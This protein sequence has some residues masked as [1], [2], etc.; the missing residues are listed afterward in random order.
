MTALA[1][2]AALIVA[3]EF[4]KAGWHGRW[5]GSHWLYMGHLVAIAAVRFAAAAPG[6]GFIAHMALLSVVATVASYYILLKSYILLQG[7]TGWWWEPLSKRRLEPGREYG[8]WLDGTSVFAV[9]EDGPWKGEPYVP[10]SDR[11]HVLSALSSWPV[12]LAAIY[13]LTVP[14]W[15]QWPQFAGACALWLGTAALCRW[16]IWRNPRLRPRHWT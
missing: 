13:T 15:G 10:V 9:R 7:R 12:E 3:L 1:I 6:W 4:A 16:G 2:L 11:W 5:Q 8:E 14:L